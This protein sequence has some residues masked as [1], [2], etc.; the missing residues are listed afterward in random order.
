MNKQITSSKPCRNMFTLMEMLVLLLLISLFSRFF[1]YNTT[2]DSVSE[3]MKRI[4]CQS[5]LKQIALGLNAYADDY[6]GFYPDKSGAAGL[7]QL[8]TLDYIT[9][10]KVFVCPGA[11]EVPGRIGKPLSENN[12]SYCF[13]GGMSKTDSSGRPLCW[14]KNPNH[15][16]KMNVLLVNGRI[17]PL[18]ELED[19]IKS[20]A[21]GAGHSH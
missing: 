8:R 14:D 17:I 15:E 11:K 18:Q 9:D 16:G 13:R 21:V 12:V 3:K 1:T 6:K 4:S 20:C 19:G 2:I 10:Y 7:E 5:N